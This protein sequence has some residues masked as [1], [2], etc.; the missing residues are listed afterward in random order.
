MWDTAL[1]PDLFRATQLTRVVLA[2]PKGTWPTGQ[3]RQGKAKAIPS[4]LVAERGGNRV[5]QLIRQLATFAPFEG[6]TAPSRITGDT[7]ATS[8]AHC[9]RPALW[10]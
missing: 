8:Q 10:S 2:H 6:P 7:D 3:A 4:E 9:S 5:L 1:R